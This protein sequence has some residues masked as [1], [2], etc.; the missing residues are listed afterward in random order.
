M[1]HDE[2]K[3]DVIC[4]GSANMDTIARVD[5]FPAVDD[6]VAVQRL[7]RTFGGSAANTAVGC[8]KLGLTTGFM[9]RVGADTTGEALVENFMAMGIDT[10]GIIKDLKLPS[11]QVFIAVGPKGEKKMY[12]YPG[13]PQA[14]DASDIIKMESFLSRA[15]VIHLASLKIVAPFDEAAKIAR[16]SGNIL[17]SN[18]GSLL[19]SFGWEGMNHLVSRLDILVCSR[20]ELC[21]IF[22]SAN[23]NSCIKQCFDRTSIK[24]LAVTHGSRGCNIVTRDLSLG[25][26]PPFP[27]KVV[28]TTGAGDAFTAGLLHFVLQHFKEWRQKGGMIGSGKKSI[29]ERFGDFMAEK[30][31]NRQFLLSCAHHGN[32]TASFKIQVEGGQGNLPSMDTLS[33]YLEEHLDH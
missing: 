1:S 17:S 15:M 3:L 29:H 6:Q 33:S 13:A 14:L 20:H 21:S 19:A 24:L 7:S 12:A 26:I 27:V 23:V 30:G 22:E 11:G 8:S 18:P 31:S 4:I 25:I 32:A 2:P 9:G 10:T 28:D 16:K 5:R